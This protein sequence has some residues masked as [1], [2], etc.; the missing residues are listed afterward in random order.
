M[1]LASS[2]P[3]ALRRRATL[4]CCAALSADTAPNQYFN[5][6]RHLQLISRPFNPSHTLPQHAAPGRGCLRELHTLRHPGFS[7]YHKRPGGSA[8]TLIRHIRQLTGE[9]L[10]RTLRLSLDLAQEIN[11]S[12]DRYDRRQIWAMG[13]GSMTERRACLRLVHRAGLTGAIMLLRL[14][15]MQGEGV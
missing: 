11:S 8:A 6:Q 3:R 7:Q 12:P 14:I 10:Q 13:V 1:R 15:P 2:R 4:S 9:Y 5:I